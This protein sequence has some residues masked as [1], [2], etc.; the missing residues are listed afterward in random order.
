MAGCTPD[1]R[2]MPPRDTDALGA[3]ED[4]FD[5]NSFELLDDIYNAVS[6]TA[7]QAEYCAMYRIRCHGQFCTS[8]RGVVHSAGERLHST[9][10]G[11]F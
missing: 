7:T 1:A 5:L 11:C 4:P 9:W 8:K 10:D 3:P 2:E 6:S